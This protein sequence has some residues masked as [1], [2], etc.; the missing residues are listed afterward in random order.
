[1]NK[2][3]GMS[4]WDYLAW[5]ALIGIVIWLLLKS[6]GLINTPLWVEYSP[7][8]GAVYIAGWAVEKLKR[9][10]EDIKDVKDNLSYVNKDMGKIKNNG[11]PAFSK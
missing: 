1:M 9:A 10:T 5:A 3:G 8:F 2:R 6:F 4:F 11:C 7:I